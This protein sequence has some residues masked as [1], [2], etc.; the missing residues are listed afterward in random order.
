MLLGVGE[1]GDAQSDAMKIVLRGVLTVACGLALWAIA[2]TPLCAAY[3][4]LANAALCCLD[5]D[6]SAGVASARLAPARSAARDDRSWNAALV[7]SVAAVGKVDEVLVNPRRSA[8][9][10]ALVLLTLIIAVPISARARRRCTA[11]GLPVIALYALTSVWATSQWLFAR[12]AGVVETWSPAHRLVTELMYRGL[13]V[14]ESNRYIVPLLLA[15]ILI[16]AHEYASQ[17]SAA[18]Q[19]PKRKLEGR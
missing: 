19:M 4:A 14:P 1:L 3:R 8:F 18:I 13:V 17:A 6:T 12:N 16:H 2:E 9:I 15:A 5:F 7:L 10:P 11:Q